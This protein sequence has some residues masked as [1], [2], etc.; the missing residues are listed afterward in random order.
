MKTLLFVLLGI[1]FVGSSAFL[2]NFPR[3]LLDDEDSIQIVQDF[4][5]GAWSVVGLT[6]PPNLAASCLDENTAQGLVN[7]ANQTLQY[8][9]NDNILKALQTATSFYQSI[10]PEIK[11]CVNTNSS[12]VAFYT[13]LGIADLTIPQMSKRII[14]YTMANLAEVRQEITTTNDDFQAGKYVQVGADTGNFMKDVFQGG[15]ALLGA[16]EDLNNFLNILE[17]LIEVAFI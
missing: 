1:A 2:P 4:F 3:S 16:S 11:A 13:A 9:V 15:E 6:P 7:A 5:T 14:T 8:L 12:T 17:Q 10:S